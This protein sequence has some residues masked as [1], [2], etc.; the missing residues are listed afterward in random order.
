M[1]MPLNFSLTTTEEEK[2]FRNTDTS[3]KWPHD[4][5]LNK[6]HLTIWQTSLKELGKEEPS[7]LA[8]ETFLLPNILPT[9]TKFCMV[10][11]TLAHTKY[12]A[13]VIVQKTLW[14]GEIKFL[15]AKVK[16]L[17]WVKCGWVDSK[18]LGTS[19][20]KADSG[21]TKG[22]CITVPLTSCLNGL[23]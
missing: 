7:C 17:S 14:E 23:D 1:N 22:E 8:E 2:A 6:F 21:N 18:N 4:L 12:N 3:K 15:R 19:A 16:L 5:M 10:C 20:F 13:V 11:M 9:S